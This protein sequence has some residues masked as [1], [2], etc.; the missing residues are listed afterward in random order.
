[1]ANESVLGDYIAAT[2]SQEIDLDVVRL[3]QR[4]LPNGGR[5][6]V[7]IMVDEG[8]NDESFRLHEINREDMSLL[9]I[10]VSLKSKNIYVFES[11]QLINPHVE[12]LVHL[13]REFSRKNLKAGED[14]ETSS[15]KKMNSG[16]GA[17]TKIQTRKI[18]YFPVDPFALPARMVHAE[19]HLMIRRALLSA[20]RKFLYR[21]APSP[22][23]T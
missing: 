3:T 11:Y 6:S 1:M 12:Q 20:S 15:Q 7:V 10:K 13:V 16:R 9:V 4:D 8:D 22:D 5:Y 21:F 19:A 18:S 2:L 17:K 14:E 23:M